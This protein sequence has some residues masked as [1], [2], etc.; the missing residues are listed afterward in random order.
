MFLN[1]RFY[2][3]FHRFRV[4]YSV[5]PYRKDDEKEG[6]FSRYYIMKDPTM[7]SD[8]TKRPASRKCGVELNT[9]KRAAR[10]QHVSKATAEKIAKGF[11]KTLNE[12]FVLDERPKEERGIESTSIA[13]V[14]TAT[15]AIFSTALK[16]DIIWKNQ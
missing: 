12:V 3:L 10:G 15:S 9:I 4:I 14:R 13:R 16:K 7:L 5:T 6:K 2:L 11:G 8:G 1:V